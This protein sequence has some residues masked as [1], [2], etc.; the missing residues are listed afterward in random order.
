MGRGKASTTRTLSVRVKIV[1]AALGDLAEGASFYEVQQAGLG[2]YF[3]DSLFADIDSLALY[4][5]THPKRSGA[6]RMLGRTFPYAVYY[7][8]IG[9]TVVVKAVL[10]CRRD[11]AWIRR[12]L[13][14][15]E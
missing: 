3:L 2:G 14:H 7:N 1:P 4:G 6:H 13:R 10:D 8:V 15:L 9:D 11:P 12:K 5:G